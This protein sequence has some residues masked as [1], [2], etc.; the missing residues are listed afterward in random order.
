MQ[1]VL[2]RVEPI[3]DS[4]CGRV[5]LSP[6]QPARVFGTLDQ[7]HRPPQSPG[8]N[9]GRWSPGPLSFLLPCGLC[10]RSTASI[11]LAKAPT[12]HVCKSS[13]TAVG[14]LARISGP[15]AWPSC[16]GGVTPVRRGQNWRPRPAEVETRARA[17]KNRGRPKFGPSGIPRMPRHA[18]C[19]TR[20]CV[21]RSLGWAGEP[22]D[23]KSSQRTPHGETGRCRSLAQFI[24]AFAPSPSSRCPISELKVRSG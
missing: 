8:L 11:S 6:R 7:R 16:D 17:A 21:F 24:P 15:P 20:W 2:S 4:E 12:P 22:A 14:P 18:S 9:S 10:G 13:A 19:G 5:M 3:F 23:R 1:P